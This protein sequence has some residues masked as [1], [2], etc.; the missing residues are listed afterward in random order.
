MKRVLL[1]GAMAW[2]CIAGAGVQ[3]A[4]AA[5]PL[6][7]SEV[8]NVSVLSNYVNAAHELVTSQ[9]RV[10]EGAPT[11]VIDGFAAEDAW[12]TSTEGLARPVAT[13]GAVSRA[14]GP[15]NGLRVYF[16]PHITSAVRSGYGGYSHDAVAFMGGVEKMWGA[17]TFGLAANYVRG[18][19]DARH[20]MHKTSYDALT[21]T[22]YGR[23]AWRDFFTQLNIGVGK[24]WGD[25]QRAAWADGVLPEARLKSKDQDITMYYASLTAG[26]RFQVNPCWVVTPSLGIQYTHARTHSAHERANDPRALWYQKD[27]H[28]YVRMPLMVTLERPMRT[29]NMMITPFARLGVV[30]EWHFD[31]PGRTVSRAASGGAVAVNQYIHGAKPRRVT[32][33]IGAGIN[34]KVGLRTDISA[35]WD[36]EAAKNYRNNVWNLGVGFS[37]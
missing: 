26:Y 14:Y 2:A 20:E 36:F 21:G 1:Y 8:P 10:L 27:S 4:A 7:A 13:G 35:S 37:F 17:M 15:I 22:L 11:R 29:Y 33:Q 30:P 34:M 31:R 16:T 25:S 32:G 18:D 5:D 9:L 19:Y 28:N 3:H 23:F 12:L 6:P 24:M